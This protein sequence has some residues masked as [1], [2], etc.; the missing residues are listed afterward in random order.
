MHKNSHMSA[1]I[2][3]SRKRKKI[4]VTQ[5]RFCGKFLGTIGHMAGYA[6]KTRQWWW[7][8]EVGWKCPRLSAAGIFGS[9]CIIRGRNFPHPATA[10]R[11]RRRRHRRRHPFPRFRG[12]SRRPTTSTGDRGPRR[13]REKAGCGSWPRGGDGGDHRRDGGEAGGGGRG[14]SSAVHHPKQLLCCLQRTRAAAE[15]A[16]AAAAEA[17]ATAIQNAAARPRPPAASPSEILPQLGYWCALI[18]L[19]DDWRRRRAPGL[20]GGTCTL[21]RRTHGPTV[22][23]TWRTAVMNAAQRSADYLPSTIDVL[24]LISQHTFLSCSPI[25]SSTRVKLHPHSRRRSRRYDLS[26]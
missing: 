6:H 18:T 9:L 5:R 2:S 11:R 25:C 21:S 13:Q 1:S 19:K 26:K 22:Y 15:A 3:I 23:G 8:D 17:E 20:C 24:P 12:A 4:C 16:R 14:E 7:P 10:S